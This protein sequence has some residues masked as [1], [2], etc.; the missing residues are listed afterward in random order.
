MENKISGIQLQN[1]FKSYFKNSTEFNLLTTDSGKLSTKF[2]LTSTEIR[3]RF[4]ISKRTLNIFSFI[5]NHH[6]LL[7]YFRIKPQEFITDSIKV[8]FKDRLNPPNSHGEI[9]IELKTFEDIEL[10]YQLL[11]IRHLKLI[12]R[13]PEKIIYPDEVDSE[14]EYVEGKTKKVLVNSYERNPIARKKCIE[15]YG[16]NCQVCDFNFKEQFGELGEDFIHVH[17]IK[18]MATME[19]E[20]SVNP[21]TDL[22]PVCPNCH[23][24]LHK[25]KPAYSIE[26]LKQIMN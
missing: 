25:K 11:F 22:V 23:S 8:F 16:L 20:Y 26:E 6:H 14:I 21:L 15:H 4:K 17:H 2:Q 19:N 3:T 18:D 24:M 7:F 10:I 12:N 1:Q 13:N 9:T 5:T